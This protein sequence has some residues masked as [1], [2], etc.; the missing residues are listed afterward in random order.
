MTFL[1]RPWS[2][3]SVC[4]GKNWIRLRRIPLGGKTRERATDAEELPKAAAA[5]ACG[6]V[7]AGL[8]RVFFA[9]SRGVLLG[10]LGFVRSRRFLRLWV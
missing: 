2:A 8:V 1:W 9:R 10:W 4:I 7:L 3:V 5:R 6:I